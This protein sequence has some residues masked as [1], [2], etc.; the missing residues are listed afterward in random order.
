MIE[1]ISGQLASI[2][3]L[4]AIGSIV[5]ATEINSCGA[6]SRVTRVDNRGTTVAVRFSISP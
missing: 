6:V 1:I 3:V 5:T 4:I 2:G